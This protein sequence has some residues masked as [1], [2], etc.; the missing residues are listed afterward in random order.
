[1]TCY[2]KTLVKI[3][4]V[5]FCFLFLQNC[6]VNNSEYNKINLEYEKAIVSGQRIPI[7]YNNNVQFDFL[8]VKLVDKKTVIE[9][10]GK[11][12]I[13][14]NSGEYVI[15]RFLRTDLTLHNSYFLRFVFSN[16]NETIVYENPVSIDRSIIVKSFCS[17][18]NC[19]VLSG[20]VVQNTINRLDIKTYRIAVKR[21]EYIITTPYESFSIDHEFNSPVNNDYLENLVFRDVTESYSSYISSILIKAYD[22]QGNVA[23]T[24]LPFK[25]VRP[26]EVKHFGKYELAET[27]EPVPVTG[28]IPGSVGNNVQYSESEVETR[29]NSV[30]ITISNNW[31]SSNSSSINNTQMEGISVGETS[32]TVLS[33]SLS[34][35]ETF[36]E[37][38]TQSNSESTG[39]NINFSSSDG[40]NWSWSIDEGNSQSNLNSNTNSNSIGAS[41]SVTTGFSGEGSLPF[42]AKASGKVEVSAGVSATV[43]SSSTEGQTNSSSN[44]RGYATGGTSQNQK[45]FG[46]VNNEARSHSLSGSYVLS[47]STSSTITESSGLSSGRVWNMSESISS[48]QTVSEGNS[49][50]LS[51]TIVDSSS[52]STTFSYSAYIPRG[53]FG[54]F[55]RQT[56]RYVKL[57]E[58]ITYDLNGYPSHAGYIIMNTW[59]WAP[60]LTIGEGCGEIL[61]PNL[62]EAVCHIPPCGE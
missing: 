4:F 17:T 43:G 2:F 33:S 30:S 13:D 8:E 1:M 38:N 52:S 6:A 48:G 54:I 9:S 31:N 59:A 24:S 18:S 25:V 22:E 23:E 60:E 55:Y 19:D 20:N 57:S 51:E 45:S 28:C 39:S 46:S 44:S 16:D 36:G 50:S 10:Y 53:R 49:E 34:E 3:N 37:T 12:D 21:I 5:L 7:K 40:E 29:Q 42:L 15:N 56:S 41:G 47:S 62:P 26:I 14:L 35:S 61:I 11:K 32:N 27:Y 58:V